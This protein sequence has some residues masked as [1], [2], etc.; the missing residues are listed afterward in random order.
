METEGV[1]HGRTLKR[2][3]FKLA[4]ASKKVDNVRSVKHFRSVKTLL[5][6]KIK[7]RDLSFPLPKPHQCSTGGVFR[8]T[9]GTLE[10]NPGFSLPHPQFVTHK[11]VIRPLDRSVSPTFQQEFGSLMRVYNFP[12]VYIVRAS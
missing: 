9:R 5:L 2:L 7:D 11:R 6:Y 10:G 3:A 8:V 12:A 4:S 1:R